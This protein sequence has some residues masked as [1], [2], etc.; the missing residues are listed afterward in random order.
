MIAA[1]VQFMT[2][3]NH[4]LYSLQ[5]GRRTNPAADIEVGE[6]VWIGLQ[7]FVMKGS[8]IGAG[9]VIGLRSMVSGTN[10]REL[11]GRGHAG[12]GPA[13]RYWLG[14][15]TLDRGWQRQYA[16]ASRFALAALTERAARC[17]NVM[18]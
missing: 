5:S 16:A 2:S 14:P 13:H 1:D 11:P 8:R 17:S 3:D 18:A 6:H 10:P 4:T 12:A 15:Q 7:C 9:S